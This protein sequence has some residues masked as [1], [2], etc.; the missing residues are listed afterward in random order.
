MPSAMRGNTDRVEGEI[1]S[2]DQPGGA[3]SG[4]DQAGGEQAA[5][6]ETLA[7]D[8]KVFSW[9]HEIAAHFAKHGSENEKCYEV[10]LDYEEFQNGPEAY[11]VIASSPSQAKRRAVECFIS[12]L[13]QEA[14]LIP[15]KTLFAVSA[16]KGNKAKD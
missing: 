5:G 7:A 9:V 3:S 11:Y 13:H 14:E 4:E 6:A 12:E 8:H 2:T 10:R 16:A 15:W 1:L